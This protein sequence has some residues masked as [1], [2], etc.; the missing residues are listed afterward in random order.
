MAY[1]ASPATTAHMENSRIA[2]ETAHTP[3][4]SKAKSTEAMAASAMVNRIA[5]LL[6]LAAMM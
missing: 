6:Y 1:P 2:G 5:V 3:N 4:L